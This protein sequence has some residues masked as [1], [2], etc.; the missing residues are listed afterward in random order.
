MTES[1]PP[2]Q[3]VIALDV[4]QKN[5]GACAILGGADPQ[6]REDEIT[7][8]AVLEVDPAS[9]DSFARGLEP[10]LG[11]WLGDDP[12][13][14]V[15]VVERQPARNVKMTRLQHFI[16]MWCAVRGARVVVQDAQHKLSFALSSP[17]SPAED[18]PNWNYRTRKRVAVQT[19][20][21]YLEWARGEGLEWAG[22]WEAHLAGSRKK[23][24]LADSLLHAMAYAHH[25]G[26]MEA[27]RHR[28]ARA[29]ASKPLKVVA[30]KPTPA[31]LA[32]G[33]LSKS[34]IKYVLT[35]GWEGGPPEALKG[36][37]KSVDREFGSMR[38]CRE[39]CGLPPA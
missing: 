17:W 13:A 31:Q 22:A 39:A 7:G 6:G 28:A 26:P 1:A 25:V 14:G 35:R 24:D 27:A 15:V 18:L 12:G 30:R 5:L 23:D 29:A 11:P 8:W 4:G 32:R 16:E 20:T 3:R 36:F 21:R 34:A 33:R 19:S 38:E 10:V 37:V 2:R 9:A